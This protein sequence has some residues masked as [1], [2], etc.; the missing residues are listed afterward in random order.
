MSP[1][2]VLVVQLWIVPGQLAE[3]ERFETAATSIIA[4]HGGRIE[5]RVAVQGAS[6]S[7]SPDEV[8]VVTFPSRAAYEGYRADPALS[9]L[10]VLRAK[11][12]LRT[13]VWEGVDL[14]P[15]GA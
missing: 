15:F 12:V 4:G 6:G 7:D 9:S 8:H 3:F 14:P 1:P 5:R 11:A 10:S 2:T 13:V